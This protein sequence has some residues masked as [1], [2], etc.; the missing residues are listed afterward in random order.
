MNRTPVDDTGFARIA[1]GYAYDRDL[2]LQV[3]VLSTQ[4]HDGRELPYLTDK[5]RFRSIHEQVVVGYFAYPREAP[6]RGSPAVL[7]L[8]GFNRF[9][10]I[11]DTWCRAWLDILAREGY[12]VLAI[13]QHG[14]GERLIPDRDLIFINPDLGPDER[15]ATVRQKVV[16]ARRAIDY[17]HSRVEVDTGRIG[18]M[19][20]SMGGFVS[21]LTA[22]LEDRL[23]AVV[24]DIAT[25]WP[26]DKA[27]DDP[28]AR[29]WHTLNFAPR[30]SAPVLMVY[31]KH[32]GVEA[33][34]ELFDALPE[35][36]HIIWHDAD[37]HVILVEDERADA[38]EWFARH[39][40]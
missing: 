26:V 10:G 11:Q 40:R 19:G 32:D 30:I 5:V 2:P 39:L 12:C 6:D 18:L 35:P 20:Q 9:R 7:L 17:L 33:G 24:L 28:L 21:C 8:H 22:G 3:E 36:R 15:R 27:T 34:Q 31:S 14:F 38:V 1:A 23:A 37:D 13:D 29:L 4:T 16:D 25:A